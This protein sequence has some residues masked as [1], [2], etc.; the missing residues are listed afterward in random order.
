M[1]FDS[2]GDAF[3]VQASSFE[4][5]AEIK[6]RACD[7]ANHKQMWFMDYYGQLRLRF[8]DEM[9]L[10]WKGK[11]LKMSS[12]C[13]KKKSPSA[14]SSKSKM[15]DA[16]YRFFIDEENNQ[17][18]ADRKDSLDL[19]HL[20]VPRKKIL[21]AMRL[22]H[23][24]PTNVEMN[25]SINKFQLKW[26]ISDASQTPSQVPSTSMNPSPAPSSIPSETPSECVDE[27]GWTV[28]GDSEFQNMT[29]AHIDGDPEKWCDLLQG[30]S[31]TQNLS[32]SISEA[33]CLCHGSTFKTT[34]PSTA[35]S[36]KPSI[37][38][39]PTLHEY[40]SS[41]PSS[42]PSVCRDEPNWH[43]KTQK[44]D[45]TVVEVSCAMFG[46][47]EELCEQFK[48]FEHEAKTPALACCICGGGDH[49]SVAPSTSPSSQPSS[50]PSFQ[51]SVSSSK[52][53]AHGMCTRLI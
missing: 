28:G 24:N 5:D 42:Q 8:N 51:P 45:G 16:K 53:R 41:E 15:E 1:P 52:L 9:C 22:F 25:E 6:M 33:C 30:I 12:K 37:S 19:T 29:C 39:L 34:Y 50:E 27:E 14:K 35:P 3:C 32:K 4:E 23:P 26:I 7:S 43:F 49:Q 13:K 44:D 46:D 31:S 20:G 2:S 40:P 11:F 36:S 38:Q 17:I 18:S 10:I 21:Q 48:D 47:N